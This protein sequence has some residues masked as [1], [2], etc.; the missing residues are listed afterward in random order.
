MGRLSA[1]LFVFCMALIAGSVGAIAYLSFAFTGG[2]AAVVAIAVMTALVAVNA[3]TSRERDRY[4]IGAQIADLSRGTADIARQVSELDRRMVAL[5]N[6]V[7]AAALRT[8]AAT[9]PLATELGELGGLVKDLADAVAAHDQMLESAVASAPPRHTAPPP[10]PAAPIPAP[11]YAAQRAAAEEVGEPAAPDLIEPQPVPGVV[12]SGPFRGLEPAEI[13]TRIGRAIEANRIELFLQPIVTLPQ[14]KVRY[15][16]ALAR[17]R[18]DDG[19]LLTPDEFLGH[20][21]AGGLLPAIDNLMVFRCVQV[22]R[23]LS[24]KNREVGIFCN[25]SAGTLADARVFKELTDFLDANRALA[26]YLVFEFAQAAI[27]AIGP[28]EEECIASL[29]DLGFRFS[30]D[31]VADLRMEPRELAERGFRFIKVP[32]TLL[33]SRTGTPQG[34]IHPADFSDLLGRYGIDLIA[35]KI[36][37]EGTVVDLLDYDVRF[38]QGFLFSPPRP[39]RTEVL[40]GIADRPTPPARAGERPAPPQ[41]A[42]AAPAAPAEPRPGTSRT[43]A[44]AQLARGIAARRAQGG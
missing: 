28:I 8:H 42:E 4:D 37:S 1:V 6:E 7:A 21:E 38:G 10:F 11:A 16:E 26:P 40:Q 13:F 3:V 33:L 23:R 5:E 35:E 18:H 24:T 39:V 19:S 9:A 41:T 31:H 44:I 20:A 22:V 30:I 25:V 34:D 12:Q 27:R 32:A 17:L 36:E 14:R 43:T 15:Y 29:A 2:E